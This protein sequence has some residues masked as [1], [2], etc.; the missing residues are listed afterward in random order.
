MCIALSAGS[1]D[2]ITSLKNLGENIEENTHLGMI[3]PNC[4]T[5]SSEIHT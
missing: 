2:E 4:D 1:W 5:L 3:S